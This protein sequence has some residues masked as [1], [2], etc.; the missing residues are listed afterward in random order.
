MVRPAI[1]SASP[2]DIEVAPIAVRSEA[3]RAARINLRQF[4][5][6]RECQ[7]DRASQGVAFTFA[8]IVRDLELSLAAI[9]QSLA[10]G[11]ER[12]T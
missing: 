11:V 5:P 9:S 1:A 8:R 4:S 10:E 12:V 2:F 3:I 6:T 7:S